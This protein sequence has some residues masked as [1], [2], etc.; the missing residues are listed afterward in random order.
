LDR[1]VE[2][3]HF[4]RHLREGTRRRAGGFEQRELTVATEVPQPAGPLLARLQAELLAVEPARPAEGLGGQ[5]R[6][7]RARAERRHASPRAERAL[8]D[9]AASFATTLICSTPPSAREMMQPRLASSARSRNASSSIPGISPSVARSI[10]WIVGAPSTK[11]RCTL[12]SVRS[13]P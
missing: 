2:I 5:P 10:C 6:R 3:L 4:P 9:G 7:D 12:A 11:R 1:R 8:P 13:R